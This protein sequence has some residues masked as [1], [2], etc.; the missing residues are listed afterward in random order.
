MEKYKKDIKNN[1]L[2]ISAPTWNDEFE[3]PDGSHSVSDIQ[4]YFEYILKLHRE[5]T[6][7][8]GRKIYVNK[9]EKRITF[10][11][12]TGYYLKLSTLET[13]RLFGSTKSK[14]TKDKNGEIVPHL[15]ITGVVLVHC[16]IVN[17]NYQQNSKFVLSK[18]FGQFFDISPLKKVYFQLNNF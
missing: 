9:T 6:D 18:S 10:R 12:E 2:K 7:N 15:E 13:I 14:I 4:N 8:P 11:I 17:N 3:L 1:K 16:N 5:K